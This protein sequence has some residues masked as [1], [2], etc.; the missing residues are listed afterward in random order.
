MKPYG[1]EKKIKGGTGYRIGNWK[2]DHHLHRGF[3]KI[4]NWW[5]DMDTVL[6]RSRMKQIFKYQLA[7]ERHQHA[8]L[9]LNKM[10]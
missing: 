9:Q 2:V 10:Q 3:H 1:R 8:T 7:N 6:T 5:E 4:A